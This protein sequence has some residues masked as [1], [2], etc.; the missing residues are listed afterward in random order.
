M[1]NSNWIHEM[2]WEEI[3]EYLKSN[4]I[5]LVPVGATEQHGRHMTLFMDTGWAVGICKGVAKLSN[6]LIAP[7]VHYGWGPH[8]LAYPG[9]LTL[10]SQTLVQVCIDI[11]ES[12]A[13]HGF[14]KIIFVNGNRV[15]NLPAM[16]MAASAL[17]HSTGAYVAVADAGL[18]AKKAVRAICDS[19]AGGLGHAGE[20][21]TSYMLHHW[22]EQVQMEKAEKSNRKHARFS[23]SAGQLE[24]PFD[25]ESV[26]VPAIA[27]EFFQATQ[28][29]G[30]TAGDPTRA[31]AEKGKLIH[32]AITNSLADFLKEV[33][34]PKKV[35][36]RAGLRIPS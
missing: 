30:G 10:R 22:P 12:L 5:A 24:D 14:K 28:A 35:N 4:D 1:N 6:A 26:Y 16:Q 33:V 2:T 3:A 11:G 29:S 27:D 19:D 34:V 8:H 36:L 20:S 18:I 7:P 23:T 9:T 15:A 13:Y 32:E 21:E 17:R 25:G 31:T